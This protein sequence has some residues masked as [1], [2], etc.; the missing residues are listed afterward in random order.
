MSVVAA[1]LCGF[2]LDLLLADPPAFPHPVVWMGRAIGVLERFLRPRFPQT[3]CGQRAAGAVLAATLPVGTLAL[4][5]AVCLVT[6]RIHP[7]LGFAVQ[8]LWSWQALAVRGLAQESR[9]VYEQPVSYTHLM[10]GGKHAQIRV[11]V[12]GIL[13]AAQTYLV[14]DDH[15][16]LALFL[17]R[18]HT[19]QKRSQYRLL[20]PHAA[21]G[22]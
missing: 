15:Q 19:G 3:R 12:P 16:V 20:F 13:F 17:Q 1:A 4:S 2:V 7:A 14:A 22:I 6:W 21:G 5:G 9:R 10:S 18:R 8:V 11:C